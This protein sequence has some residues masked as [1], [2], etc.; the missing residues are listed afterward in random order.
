[1][2]RV[3]HFQTQSMTPVVFYFFRVRVVE[4][5]ES[6]IVVSVCVCSVT[7]SGQV[8]CQVRVQRKEMEET[9]RGRGLDDYKR[10][11]GWRL[12]ERFLIYGFTD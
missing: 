2:T 12:R 9:R 5:N 8:F 1:M 11:G 3:T 6:S 10:G 4:Y 7:P